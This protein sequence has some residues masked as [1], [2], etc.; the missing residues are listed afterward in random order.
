MVLLQ[1]HDELVPS[2]KPS[3]LGL[4]QDSTRI[5]ASLRIGVN[6]IH[7]VGLVRVSMS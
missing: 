6:P 5:T 4:T 7:N 3:P 1:R 2:S